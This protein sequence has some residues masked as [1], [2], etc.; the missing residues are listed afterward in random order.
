[1]GY[2]HGP[3]I[4]QNTTELSLRRSTDNTRHMSLS[5]IAIYSQ[6]V[7]YIFLRKEDWYKLQYEKVKCNGRS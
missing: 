3:T 1:V 2:V 6:Q 4:P 5:A 7:L